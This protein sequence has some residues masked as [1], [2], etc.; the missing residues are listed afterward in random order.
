MDGT[1]DWSIDGV[2]VIM[3]SVKK[4]ITL[5]E[6]CG[7]IIEELKKIKYCIK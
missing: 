3:I 6:G 2:G 5:C 7:I 1:V 4:G